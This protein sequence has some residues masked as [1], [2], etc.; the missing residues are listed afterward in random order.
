MRV[1]LLKL[2]DD[3]TEFIMFGTKQQLNKTTPTQITIGNDIIRCAEAVKNLGVWFDT[4]LKHT[5]H[6]NKLTS[7]LHLQFRNIARIHHHLDHR[8]IKAIIQILIL[9]RLDYCNGVLAGIP[10]YNIMKLQCF[11]N[12]ACRIVVQA[13]KYYHISH[14]MFNLHWLQIEDRIMFKV[15]MLVYK[16]TNDQALPYLKDLIIR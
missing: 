3:K 2:N 4:E 16:C 9:L 5:I 11:Q 8:T 14:H 1:N 10:K 12:M 13:G 6:I 15:A 7:S